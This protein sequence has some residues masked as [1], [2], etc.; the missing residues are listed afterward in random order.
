[1]LECLVASAVR[2]HKRPLVARH[3]PVEL[4]LADEIAVWTDRALELRVNQKLCILR[5]TETALSI[6]NS[7][8]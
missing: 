2:A 8:F 3:V 4:A 5:L 7:L 1:M 6:G